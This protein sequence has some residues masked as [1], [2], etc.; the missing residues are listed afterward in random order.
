MGFKL[1]L[2]LLFIIFTQGCP[3]QLAAVL[4][5]GPAQY[6]TSIK[7]QQYITRIV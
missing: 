6:N 2:L 4:T 1:L 3:N 5:R 7:H